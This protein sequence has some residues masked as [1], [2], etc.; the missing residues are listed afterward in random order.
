MPDTKE[1]YR[2]MIT[3]G[4]YRVIVSEEHPGCPHCGGGKMWDVVHVEDGEEVAESVT[5]GD[6][7]SAEDLTDVMNRAHHAAAEVTIDLLEQYHSSQDAQADA[8]D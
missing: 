1:D 4:P 6:E 5:F 3:E 7:E 2:K 8:M